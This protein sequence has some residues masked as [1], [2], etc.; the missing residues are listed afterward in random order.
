M[1]T[2]GTETAGSIISPSSTQG[3][4]G[5]RPTV[6]LVPG[7]GIAPIDASQDTAGPMVRTVADAALTLQSIAGARTDP[8]NEEYAGHQGPGLHDHR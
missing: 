2:I 1:L 5:L 7:Y 4:V 6:G 8:D 3:I